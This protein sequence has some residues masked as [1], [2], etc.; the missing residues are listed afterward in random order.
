MCKL[1]STHTKKTKTTTQTKTKPTNS[2]SRVGWRFAVSDS[3]I[4][5]CLVHSNMFWVFSFHPL[6]IEPVNAKPPSECRCGLCLVPS[7]QGSPS[8]WRAIRKILRDQRMSVMIGAE[9]KK[10]RH[11]K[12]WTNSMLISNMRR[13]EKRVVMARQPKPKPVTTRFKIQMYSHW[14]PYEETR[15]SKKSANPVTALSTEKQKRP[16]CRFYSKIGITHSKMTD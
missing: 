16:F 7:S 3:G 12:C 5:W 1:Q 14:P 15:S 9:A 10:W 11:Y 2:S 13:Q 6:A 4:T 8:S